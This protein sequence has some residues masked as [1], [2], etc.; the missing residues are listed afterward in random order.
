[1]NEP[2]TCSAEAGIAAIR[3]GVRSGKPSGREFDARCQPGHR[4]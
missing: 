3:S 1:M 2:L 4:R